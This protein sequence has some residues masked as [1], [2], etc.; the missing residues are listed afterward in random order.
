MQKHVA[1][2]GKH[3]SVLPANTEIKHLTAVELKSNDKGDYIAKIDKKS[4]SG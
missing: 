2:V 1:L 3:S 4:G